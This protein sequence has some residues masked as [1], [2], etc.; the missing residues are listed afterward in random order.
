M[1]QKVYDP[2]TVFLIE[3][4]PGLFGLLGIGH[5]YVG[6]TSDGVVRLVLWLGFVWGAWIVAWLFTAVL[7]G[8]CCMPFILAAQVG[9]PIWSA[10]NLKNTLLLSGSSTVQ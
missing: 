5:I 1:Q 6:R 2:N 3:L 10:Y 9:V 8:I 4:I 7:V